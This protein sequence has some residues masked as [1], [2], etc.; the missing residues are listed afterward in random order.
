MK[1]LGITAGRK[2]GNS[3]ILMKEALRAAKEEYQAEVSWVNLHD[4]FIK[5]CT[6]CEACTMAI[7]QGRPPHC[8]F[9]GQDDMDYI[10]G[11]FMA[12]DGIIVSIPSFVNQPQGIYKRFI[13]RWLPYEV[14][15]MKAAGL[16][17]KIPERVA[18]LITVGGSTQN[19]MGLTLPSLYMSMNMQSI[20]VVDKMMATGVARPG[21]VC[22]PEKEEFM[23]QAYQ[24][25]LHVAKSCQIPYDEVEYLGADK[26]QGVC[27]ICH[28]NIIMKGTPHWDGVTFE[29]EC[30][31]C[32]AGGR[33]AA[34]EDGVIRFELVENGIEHCRNYTEGRAN[35]MFE[36]QKTQRTFFENIETA[37]AK[38]KELSAFTP[39]K[40][41]SNY[42]E[43]AKNN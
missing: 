40:L 5:T 23:K 8:I 4:M 33:L 12:A 36:I 25:G 13:D 21:H 41:E 43:Q 18:G 2:G 22:L 1:I 26:G 14:G 30:G 10:M 11:E 32:G 9:K 6:G 19:W 39:T 38:M 37:K 24:M 31:Q 16:I 7:T 3:E 35:H 42:K 15:L 27:P 28:C 34:D 20:K 29:Y 17:D